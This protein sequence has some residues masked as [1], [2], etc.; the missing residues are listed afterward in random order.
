MRTF[1]FVAAVDVVEAESDVRMRTRRTDDDCDDD[2]YYVALQ[3]K[4]GRRTEGR[5][6]VF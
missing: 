3:C 2:C 5:I 1:D 4:A 6:E